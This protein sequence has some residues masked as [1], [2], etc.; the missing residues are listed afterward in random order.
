[1]Y[2][3]APLRVNEFRVLFRLPGQ[4]VGV[5]EFRDTAACTAYDAYR[6]RLGQIARQG[7]HILRVFLLPYGLATK[8]VA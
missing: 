2:G 7:G 1:M 3:E 5:E 4:G 8:E 6:A